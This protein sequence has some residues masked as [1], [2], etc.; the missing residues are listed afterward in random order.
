MRISRGNN[1][2]GI[3]SLCYGATPVDTWTSDLRNDTLPS[4]SPHSVRVGQPL[5]QN[6]LLTASH[7]QLTPNYCDASWAFAITHALADG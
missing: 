7:S 4:S 1:N 6:L 3:E 2:L 5:P